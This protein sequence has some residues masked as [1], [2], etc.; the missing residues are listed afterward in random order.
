MNAAQTKT[1]QARLVE[2]VLELTQ[3]ISDAGQ[4]ADWPRAARLAEERSPLVRAITADQDAASLALIRRIQAMNGTIVN[5]ARQ[6]EAGLTDEYNEAM[7]RARA[8]QQYT[9]VALYR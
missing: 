7:G 9:R 5:E 6:F 3:A 2:R 4:L 1:E 8:A